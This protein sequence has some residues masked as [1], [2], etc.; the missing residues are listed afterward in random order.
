MPSY[1]HMMAEDVAVWTRYLKSPLVRIAEV[2][3]DVHVGKAVEPIVPGDE[4][5]ARIAAG[6]TRKRI[7]VV[8][9]VGGELWVIE[10]KPIANMTA[11]GQ[12]I[13]YW[14]LFVEEFRPHQ[15]VQAVII[16]DQCDE[17]IVAT[18]EELG[19]IV[20]ANLGEK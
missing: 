17:D 2:W 3:Y 9:A 14:C 15:A 16:C 11:V 12:V 13:S 6:V 18:C 5:G 10:I 1:P 7:D 4:L 20:I 8:A 19:V